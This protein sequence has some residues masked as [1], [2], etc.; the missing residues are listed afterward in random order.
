M[1]GHDRVPMT[2]PLIYFDNAATSFPKPSSVYSAHDSY[3]RAAGNPGRGAHDLALNSA[4]TVFE[5]RLSLAEFLGADNAERVLFTPGCTYS[6]NFVLH[7]MQLKHGDCVVTS[8]LEHNAVMRTLTKYEQSMDLKIVVVPYAK[9]GTIDPSVLA[10]VL[11][12][13]KPRLCVFAEASNVTGE[14]I[15]LESVAEICAA[16]QV[17]LL[18]DAAQT[19]GAEEKCLRHPGITYWAAPGHKG[20]MGA[21]GAGVLFVRDGEQLAPLICGGTGSSSE[22]LAMPQA[23]PDHMEPGTLA[24]PAIA[25]LGAGVDFVR[26]TGA[27]S[28]AEHEHLLATEFREWC[29]S[30]SWLKVAGNTF[31]K[32]RT[33]TSSGVAPVVSLT[34]ERLSPDRIADIL[35]REDSIAVRP[36]LH[37]AARAHETLGTSKHGLLRVSFGFFNTHDELS[38]LCDALERIHRM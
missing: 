1:R 32:K 33:V 9:T 38:T 22:A 10:E 30:K 20:L 11:E 13:A 31:A 17:K 28:I 27:S 26:K 29:F 19:A 8:A 3:L 34:H 21:P 24:G 36:G 7:G 12:A 4:R 18:V 25:A 14:R 5:S 15:P 6:I 16:R 37:C 2:K 23:Y 35:N